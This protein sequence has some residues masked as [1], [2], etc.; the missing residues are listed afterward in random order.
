MTALPNAGGDLDAEWFEVYHDIDCN[1]FD[2]TMSVPQGV[3][4]IV[5]ETRAG[6]F[7]ALRNSLSVY[8]GG[9]FLLVKYASKVDETNLQVIHDPTTLEVYIDPLSCVR[10][11]VVEVNT[12]GRISLFCFPSRRNYYRARRPHPHHVQPSI[13]HESSSPLLADPD[14]PAPE[15]D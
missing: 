2:F 11:A 12:T 9:R 13:A 5:F 8:H 15:G 7:H 3:T 1:R 4:P 14:Q 6:L 10:D